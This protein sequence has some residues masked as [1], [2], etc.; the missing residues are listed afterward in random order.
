MQDLTQYGPHELSLRVF[1]EEDIYH[2]RHDDELLSILSG[3]F[4]W[5]D[6]QVKQLVIDL[7]EDQEDS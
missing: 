2:I 1:N 5:T 3:C 6:E 4:I 7:E